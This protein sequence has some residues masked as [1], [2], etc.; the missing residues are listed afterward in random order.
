MFVLK[1]EQIK[2]HKYFTQ[3]IFFSLEKGLEGNW[4]FIKAFDFYLDMRNDACEGAF[5][6]E[7]FDEFIEDNFLTMDGNPIK[8]PDDFDFMGYDFEAYE[9][10]EE[11]HDW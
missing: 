7:S 1:L 4:T 10:G 5:G 9:F 3:P 11:R 8:V 6:I 2:D